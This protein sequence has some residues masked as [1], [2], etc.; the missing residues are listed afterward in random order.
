MFNLSLENYSKENVSK[1]ELAQELAVDGCM[2]DYEK[3]D[4]GKKGRVC[5]LDLRTFLPCCDVHW[6]DVFSSIQRIWIHIFFSEN[7]KLFLLN[8]GERP[9]D[10]AFLLLLLFSFFLVR[11]LALCIKETSVIEP[12]IHTTSGSII[13]NY[14]IYFNN[15]NNNTST[16]NIFGT[17]LNPGYCTIKWKR[18]YGESRN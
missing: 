10:L 1:S 2:Q 7:V 11:S 8:I 3:A 12:F 6:C 9:R 16:L 4:A 13:Y 15:N 14:S 18:I 17:F 5:M